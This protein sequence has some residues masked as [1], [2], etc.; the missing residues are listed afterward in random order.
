[1]HWIKVVASLLF[2][3]LLA[4]CAAQPPT[5]RAPATFYDHPLIDPRNQQPISA[6]TLARQLRDMDIVIVGEYHG[7]QASHL[8]QANLQAHLF[9]ARPQ[10][11]LTMEMF[12]ADTQAVLDAYL[13][14][15]LGEEELVEDG[16]G[17]PNHK[18]SYRPL[19]EFARWHQ[20]PVIAANAP[21]DAVRCVGRQGPEWLARLT[22]EQ[23]PWLPSDPWLDTPA[24]RE[25]FFSFMG[26]HD[27]GSAQQ[28]RINNRYHAQLLRD[29]TMASQILQA[30]RHHPGHQVLHLNGTFHSAERQGVVAALLQRQAELKIAVISPVFQGAEGTLTA[31][32]LAQGDYL[33]L[34]APL[35]ADYLD[36]GRQHEAIQARFARA[37]D[38]HCD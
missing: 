22:P 10:Q 33:Y 24:Y 17:W 3:S 18:G 35:P 30:R 27:H 5:A 7:H 4:G 21:I 25:R 15:E 34:I 26:Q 1:M 12:E 38:T 29:N 8:L 11:L 32:Q 16:R 13:A 19:L 28:T 6:E 14:G 36:T 23:A 9:A 31:D 2:A 20:L 37:R